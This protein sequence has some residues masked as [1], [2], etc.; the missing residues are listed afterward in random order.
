MRPAL[1][2]IATTLLLL[3]SFGALALSDDASY[4]PSLPV[5][6]DSDP[7]A[8]PLPRA[9]LDCVS[10]DAQI[11]SIRNIPLTITAAYLWDPLG[12]PLS[13]CNDTAGK[14][15]IRIAD[16]DFQPYQYAI[17]ELRDEKREPVPAGGRVIEFFGAEPIDIANCAVC[18]AAQGMAADL[19][20]KSGLHLFDEE[21]AH[22]Q[23]QHPEAGERMAR[24]ASASILILELH[25]QR[26]N[27][28]FLKNYD[29]YAP[30]HRLGKGGIVNCVD[31]HGDN[32]SGFQLSRSGTTGIPGTGPRPL[33][34]S[35]H[36]VHARLAQVPDAAGRTRNCRICHPS[37]WHDK[38]INDLRPEASADDPGNPRFPVR[39]ARSWEGAFNPRRDA[40]AKS[41]ASSP[42]F[43]NGIG[44]WYLNEVSLKNE[45]GE[46]VGTRRGLYCTNCHNHLADELYRYDDLRDAVSQ[47]GETLRN[48]PIDEV[49][50]AVAAGDW[51]RFRSFYADPL[52]AAAGE[53]LYSFYAK[54]K[55]TVLA[56]MVQG[57]PD[58]LPW[59]G[60][61]GE[62]VTYAAVSGGSDWWLSSSLPH[63]ADCHAPPFVENQGGQHLPVDQP[64]KYSLFRYSRAH[65]ALSCQS[66]HRSMHGLS[67]VATG[68]TKE[69]DATPLEQ[70]LR[71]RADG[72]SASSVTCA[73]CHTVNQNG[74][75]TELTGTGYDE[76]YWSS[77]VLI[78]FM[79]EADRHLTVS[80]LVAKYPL[81]L[82]REIVAKGWK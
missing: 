80:E 2:I 26:H 28:G 33:T 41:S 44:T 42:L 46:P 6:F 45:A 61:R 1:G 55:D 9:S 64:G 30:S 40:P 25:D 22:W 37:T 69:V 70:A 39:D 67:P 43:L 49:I 31:C 23:R 14:E 16:L 7:T 72:S 20:R 76:E 3:M 57:T 77:V 8:K 56:R 24:L 53:P 47:Q 81:Q 62:P 21:Y 73:A 34:E 78:H 19:S 38:G 10:I 29:P 35:I 52:V 54:R 59:N 48:L 5:N 15:S 60:A 18:H 79:R 11:A 4:G 12:L 68:G 74:V 63:C 58:L 50:G 66:C 17:V 32:M 75:P 65:G 82:A 13:A 27:T 71:Q 36:A 51:E